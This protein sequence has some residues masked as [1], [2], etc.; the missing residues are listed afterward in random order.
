MIFASRHG[1][2]SSLGLVKDKLASARAITVVTGAGISADSGVPTFRGSEGLWQYFR[3][4]D[5]ATPEAFARD[6]RSCGNGTTGDGNSSRPN[7][8]I[9][10]M[11]LSQRWSDASH[12]SG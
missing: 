3:A 12:S 8:P 9:Q 11:M 7:S 10:P 6:P 5:L 2:G 1:T 4:E